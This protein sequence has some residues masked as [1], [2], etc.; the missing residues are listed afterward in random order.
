[1]IFQPTKFGKS[2]ISSSR[3]PAWLR[4]L[5]RGTGSVGIDVRSCYEHWEN[6]GYLEY[7]PQ[8]STYSIGFGLDLQSLSGLASQIHLKS[9][10][11]GFKS[12]CKVDWENFQDLEKV[13]C[14]GCFVD[15]SIWFLQHLEDLAISNCSEKDWSNVSRMIKLATIEL[16]GEGCTDF[17]GLNSH[18]LR[19]ISIHHNC[20]LSSL[21]SDSDLSQVEDLCITACRNLGSISGV[22]KFT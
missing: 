17:K 2:I 16:I 10:S 12:K 18:R 21:E 6:L 19:S 1:M 13:Y 7:L 3:R 15:E 20:R 5:L 14:Q 9:L 11:L 22:Q 8:L 4:L